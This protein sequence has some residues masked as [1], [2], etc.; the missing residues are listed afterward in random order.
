MK[1]GE[2]P[3]SPYGGGRE[4]RKY[5]R[6]KSGQDV[7]KLIFRVQTDKNSLTGKETEMKESEK[8]ERRLLGGSSDWGKKD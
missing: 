4:G 3:T 6:E 1:E 8:G 5:L 7:E 2:H